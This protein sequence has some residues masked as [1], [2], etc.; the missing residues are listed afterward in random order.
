MVRGWRVPDTESLNWMS[1]RTSW[2]RTINY[3][4]TSHQWEYDIHQWQQITNVA[5]VHHKKSRILCWSNMPVSV[6]A[7]TELRQYC[8]TLD[9][10]TR[11]YCIV[12]GHIRAH[13]GNLWI[14]NRF[15]VWVVRPGRVEGTVTVPSRSPPMG[16]YQLPTDIYIYMA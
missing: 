9:Q 15:S 11:F 10:I 2:S 7:L 3:T 5:R 14:Y 1:R 16:S 13:A 8:S 4:R 6:L 12:P